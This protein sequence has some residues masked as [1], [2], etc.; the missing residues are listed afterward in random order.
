[1]NASHADRVLAAARGRGTSQDI[2]ALQAALAAEQAASYG[3]GIVGAHLTGTRFSAAAADCVA[4]QRARDSLAGLI[5]AR[6]GRPRPAAAAYKLPIKVSTAAQAR[7]LAITLERQVTAAYLGL[8]A[9]TN[10]A[11]RRFAADNMRAAAVRS[12]RWG[13]RPQAFPGLP[14]ASLRAAP[15]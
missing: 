14:A 12:A 3:Y 5:S 4:H 6:G 13:G 8:V 10:P 15:R 9:V 2:D 11:L 7:S 1:V